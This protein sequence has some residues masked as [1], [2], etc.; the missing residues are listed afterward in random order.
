MT[1]ISRLRGA[2]I[3]NGNLINADDISA[4]LDQLVSES[5]SQDSRLTDIES[6]N[7]TLSG[8]KTFSASPKTNGID[9]RTAD[10][11]VTV[12]EL[13]IKDGTVK[14]KSTADYTPTA[15]G[16][17][18]YDSTAHAYGVY[19]DGVA[20]T[21]YHTGNLTVSKPRGHLFGLTLSNNGSNPNN[22][23]DIAVG[24]ARTGDDTEDMTLS[25]VITKRLDAGWTV[26]TNQGG[27][28]TGSEAN[29]TWYHVW[30][31]KRTDTGVVD[32]LFSTSATS[33]TMPA[34][35]TVKRRIG[36]I[37]NG[38]DGNI[39]AFFQRGDEFMW[40]TPVLDVDVTNQSTSAI[41]RTLTTPLGLKLKALLQ[42]YG[43][44]ST[45]GP[46]IINVYSTDVTD[47][48]V[49]AT[50]APLGVVGGVSPSNASGGASQG[51]VWTNT[52]SQVNSR[53]AAAST[54]LRIA[55]AGWIDT[56]G[57]LY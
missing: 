4:E 18:G 54:T 41:A 42:V 57:R 32:V 5:N 34:N 47:S 36:S 52:S 11:G 21:L 25:S 55:T 50:A 17:L 24:V 15:N 10:S 45:G 30:L 44:T 1:Q 40:T 31:I 49:S 46:T 20:Q 2:E 28:D 16:E 23:L 3:A 13:L 9:E 33:P 7:V 48:A 22:D 27:L 8:V 14:L 35:Y 26:G 51:M 39:K 43:S 12:D 29:S 38:S 53:S 19:V 37:Y 6:E 56:R